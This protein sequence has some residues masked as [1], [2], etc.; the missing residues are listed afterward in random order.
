[1]TMERFE[2]RLPEIGFVLGATLGILTR[3]FMTLTILGFI[4]GVALSNVRA[5]QRSRG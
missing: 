5:K 4:A 3:Q 1:M 2:N